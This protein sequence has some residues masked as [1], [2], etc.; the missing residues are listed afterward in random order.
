[1]ARVLSAQDVDWV[2]PI[3]TAAPGRLAASDWGAIG[4]LSK[5]TADPLALPGIMS[6][7][8]HLSTSPERAPC[9]SSGPKA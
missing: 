3:G 9:R 8:A 6:D 1:M 4:S 2:S 7:V 5:P